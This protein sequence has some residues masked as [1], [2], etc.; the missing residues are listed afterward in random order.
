MGMKDESNKCHCR[1]FGLWGFDW[2]SKWQSV[3][4]ARANPFH[5][6]TCLC[7]LPVVSLILTAQFLLSSSFSESTLC[8]RYCRSA[9]CILLNLKIDV[10]CAMLQNRFGNR[11]L[12][13]LLCT[14]VDVVQ[15]YDWH[16]NS[17]LTI[18]FYQVLFRWMRWHKVYHLKTPPHW[19]LVSRLMPLIVVA[20]IQQRKLFYCSNDGISYII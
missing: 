10:W 9:N 18:L 16:N 14:M 13:L 11:L 3:L 4:N 6:F 20:H 12:L 15:A 7:H 17:H 8:C 5:K 19:L 1:I 2:Y